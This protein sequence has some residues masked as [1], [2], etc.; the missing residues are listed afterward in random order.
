MSRESLDKEIIAVRTGI[1]DHE[2]GG[3]TMRRRI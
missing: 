3:M 2:E 1:A